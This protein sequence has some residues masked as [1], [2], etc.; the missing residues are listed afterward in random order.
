M[1]LTFYLYQGAILPLSW[2]RGDA[3]LQHT[4]FLGYFTS[5][6]GQIGSIGAKLS[7]NKINVN[8]FFNSQKNLKNRF[9]QNFSLF[10]Y[11]KEC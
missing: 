10:F 6:L 2:G 1:V 11:Q 5:K 7:T 9:F 3:N 4:V 8:F